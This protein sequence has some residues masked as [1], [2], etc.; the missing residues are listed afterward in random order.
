[1]VRR[2]STSTG[3]GQTAAVR[4]VIIVNVSEGRS[5]TPPVV[6]LSW[7]LVSWYLCVR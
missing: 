5:L 1:L 7:M 6:L 4:Y 2:Q 3:C